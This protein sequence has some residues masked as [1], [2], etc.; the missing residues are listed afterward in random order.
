M[1]MLSK[2]ATAAAAALI[3]GAAQADTIIDLFAGTQGPVSDD[4]AA[5]NM[6]WAGQYGPDATIQGLYRD[7]GVQKVSGADEPPGGFVGTSASVFAGTYN[8]SVDAGAV[9]R[10]VVRWD[11][12]TDAGAGPSTITASGG[13]SGHFISTGLGSGMGMSLNAADQFQFDVLISDLDF[14]FWIE[15]YDTSGEYSK[16]K[17]ESQAHFASVSTPIPVAAFIGLCAGGPTEFA[18]PG[19]ADNDDVIAGACSSAAFD[20]SSIG[21]MQ[22]IMES[23]DVGSVDLRVQA[24]R[25][26][27][28]PGILALVGAGLLGAAGAARRRRRA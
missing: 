19:D 13:I 15:L 3:A 8:W 22:I 25:V 20:P 23:S 12:I 21:A 24:L 4:F 6:V 5:G 26:I 28:E 2:L 18:D 1:R 17:F 10:A 9:G 7:I 27:P 11:G 14:T 16:I